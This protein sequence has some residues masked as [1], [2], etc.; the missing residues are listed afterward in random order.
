MAENMGRTMM[1]SGSQFAT[2]EA[3]DRPAA[4]KR[5][6]RPELTMLA[7][8]QTAASYFPGADGPNVNSQAGS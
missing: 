1:N 4:P 8:E 5:W 6:T 7:V 2:G 3:G